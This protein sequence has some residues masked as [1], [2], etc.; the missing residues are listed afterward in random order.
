M[1]ECILVIDDQASIRTMLR[2]Y[3]T[4]QGMTVHCVSNGREGL[5]LARDV[6]PDIVILD[7]MMPEMDGFEFLRAFR[8]ASNAP[9]LMV[10]ARVEEA[11]KVLGLEFGADDY[12][13]KPF[14]LRELLARIRAILRRTRG[15]ETLQP[16]YRWGTLEVDSGTRRVKS[17]RGTISLTPTEYQ[18]L[19]ALITS[20]GRVFS[21]ADLL[22][23]VSDQN[24]GHSPRT[25]DVH[26]RNIRS[27]V[28]LDDQESS[29]IETVFGVGYRLS[30][31]P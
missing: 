23:L 30:E 31:S 2:E 6:Q 9:V 18:I 19:L 5:F 20:P 7:V 21:R 14:S 29:L 3:L 15:S 13:T 27:K 22:N 26:V 24:S 25:V 1:N 11:D 12:L 17:A 28:D 4:E 16:V 10:T 8:Q